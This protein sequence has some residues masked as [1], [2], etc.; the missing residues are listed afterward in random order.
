MSSYNIF[1]I[2]ICNEILLLHPEILIWI[3]YWPKSSMLKEMSSKCIS[4]I[5]SCEISRW[6]PWSSFDHI[7]LIIKCRHG[8]VVVNRMNFKSLKWIHWCSGP[9][10]NISSRVIYTSD[11]ISVNW[12]RWS[13]HKAYVGSIFF[14]IEIDVIEHCMVLIFCRE[15]DGFPS[16]F[17]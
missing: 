14:V 7:M 17:R 1:W 9:L 12:S 6:D 3:F 5:W 11:E 16:F 2:M 8:E 4:W 10:P 15:S 13:S